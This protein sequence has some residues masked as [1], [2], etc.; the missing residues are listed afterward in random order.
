MPELFCRAL[1]LQN[2]LHIITDSEE[3]IN[4]KRNNNNNATTHRTVSTDFCI[5]I[6]RT[7]K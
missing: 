5:L 4:E 1:P 3:E 6:I 7:A 2:S